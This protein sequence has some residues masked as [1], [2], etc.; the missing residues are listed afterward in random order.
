MVKAVG[1]E[2]F[3]LV[4]LAGVAV[5]AIVRHSFYVNFEPGE[6]CVPE[7]GCY[8]LKEPSD[9]SGT[10]ISD[11]HSRLPSVCKV[12]TVSD[13]RLGA[14]APENET[15]NAEDAAVTQRS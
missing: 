14:M 5:A 11:R 9:S 15:L 6:E 12:K 1:K 3:F 8:V 13:A 2:N 10:K 7:S 4:G